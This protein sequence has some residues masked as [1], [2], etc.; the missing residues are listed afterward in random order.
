MFDNLFGG[1]R[2]PAVRCLP[3]GSGYRIPA[4]GCF[5]Q[6]VVRVDGLKGEGLG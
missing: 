1:M 4:V 3:A 2:M 6:E 5:I